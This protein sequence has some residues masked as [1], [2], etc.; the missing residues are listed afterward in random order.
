MVL[1]AFLNIKIIRYKSVKFC[2]YLRDSKVVRYIRKFV[3]PEFVI[4]EFAMI[5]LDFSR[6]LKETSL[7]P[8][9]R[10]ICVLT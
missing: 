2:H 3:I 5:S 4:N 7:Y 6:G 8:R 9:F 10:Y 1:Q